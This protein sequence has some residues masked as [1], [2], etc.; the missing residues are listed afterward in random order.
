MSEPRGNAPFDANLE[1]LELTLA[2]AYEYE[3]QN[4]LTFVVEPTPFV[5]EIN[6]EP[7]RVW[8]GSNTVG[9]RCLLLVRIVTCQ[10]E[11][12]QAAFAAR[13]L[14]QKALDTEHGFQPIDRRYF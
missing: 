9:Q 14:E 6:D 3:I 2:R 7:H 10:D 1:D 8:K 5:T 12:L 11:A 4:P 13:L